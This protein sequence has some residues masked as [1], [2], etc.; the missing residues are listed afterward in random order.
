M[1]GRVNEENWRTVGSLIF[2]IVKTKRGY[3]VFRTLGDEKGWPRGR[4]KEIKVF[5]LEPLAVIW[6]S[7]E[8]L[9]I[10]PTAWQRVGAPDHELR[11][12]RFFKAQQ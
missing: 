6:A 11:Y 10:D 1:P 3:V 12:I 8:P 5:D 9:S 2:R 7:N 4:F